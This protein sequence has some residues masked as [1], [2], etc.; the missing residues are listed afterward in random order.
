VEGI[1]DVMTPFGAMPRADIDPRGRGA[2]PIPGRNERTGLSVGGYPCTYGVSFVMAAGFDEHGPVGRCLLAY[3]QS[4]D[5]RSP[6]YSDQTRAW[7]DGQMRP[8]RFH[9]HDV[10]A[11]AV[12]S[13]TVTGPRH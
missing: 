7:A 1:A 6:H 3:G 2:E 12:T 5:E 13:M 11:A 10:E 8:I 9:R 4:S